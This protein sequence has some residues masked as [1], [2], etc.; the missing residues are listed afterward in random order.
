MRVGFPTCFQVRDSGLG[1]PGEIACRGFLVHAVCFSRS[2]VIRPQHDEALTGEVVGNA[3][4][5]FM[6]GKRSVPIL[7]S[8]ARHDDHGGEGAFSSGEGQRA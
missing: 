5:G 3:E 8:C 4:K 6:P 1:I 2:P 7:F